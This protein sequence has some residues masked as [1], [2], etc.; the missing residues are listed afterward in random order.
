MK[1]MIIA[2]ATIALAVVAQA[3]TVK[4]S[5][6]NIYTSDAGSTTKAGNTYLA[7]CYV[8]DAT[9]M[10]SVIAQ[11]KAGDEAAISGAATTK[12][13]SAG[14]LASSGYGSYGAGDTVSAFAII[15]DAKT[16]ADA[17]NYLV[18]APMEY[19]FGTASETKSLAWGSQASNTWQST[20]A[21]PEPTSGLLLLLGMAGL[22]L[23]RK[24]A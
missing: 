14:L 13:L 7:L 23:R 3:A 21:V 11:I 10:E 9:T 20:A 6:N 24:N 5:A 19:T 22:A 1:K 12:T 17:N 15:L 18:L 4:W 8:G 16:V 2:A